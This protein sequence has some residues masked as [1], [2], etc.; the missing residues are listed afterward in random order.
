MKWTLDTEEHVSHV[1]FCAERSVGSCPAI[2]GLHHARSQTEPVLS[3]ICNNH[4]ANMSRVHKIDHRHN[5][6][7]SC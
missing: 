4:P 5:N 6:I 7:M 1:I 3:E 2:A